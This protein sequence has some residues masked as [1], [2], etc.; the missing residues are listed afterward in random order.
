RRTSD[1]GQ[2]LE[3]WI[4]EWFNPIADG[5]ILLHQSG[6]PTIFY[7]DYY[8][9][10]SID[11]KG[12]QETLD[13]LLALRREN[14]YGDQHDQFDHR[15]CIGYTRTGDDEHPDGLAF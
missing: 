4:D 1:L 14:A 13:K 15:N 5:L 9:I 6:L 2:A 11:Y 3:P 8:G 7:G 12:F 10:E